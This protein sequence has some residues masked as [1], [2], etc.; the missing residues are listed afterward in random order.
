MK[1]GARTDAKVPAVRLALDA[2]AARGRVGEE[3]RDALLRGGAQEVAL[4]RPGGMDGRRVSL[5]HRENESKS[6]HS[7][8]IFRAGQAG[9]VGQERDLGPCEGVRGQEQVELRI[10]PSQRGRLRASTV[11][12]PD[13]GVGGSR[14]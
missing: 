14:G 5:G 2:C 10:E 6:G 9:E 12:C 4:L 7:R 3:D 8:V 13:V 1:G 11:S